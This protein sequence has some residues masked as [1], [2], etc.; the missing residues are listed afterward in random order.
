MV[1]KLTAE[2]LLSS[3]VRSSIGLPAPENDFENQ[4]DQTRYI[5]SEEGKLSLRIKFQKQITKLSHSDT[6]P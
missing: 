2:P 1:L 5:V 4:T 3:G 6:F